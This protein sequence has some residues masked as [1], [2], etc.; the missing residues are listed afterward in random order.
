MEI[1]HETP[2]IKELEKK[3]GYDA[4][5]WFIEA[6]A[7]DVEMIDDMA[8]HKPWQK[9]DI[10]EEVKLR[11]EMARIP[12]SDHLKNKEFLEEHKKTQN[13]LG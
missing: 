11:F 1:T 2:N 6:L 13:L 9:L 7:L 8:Y 3:M 10:P 4:I 12:M 5:E